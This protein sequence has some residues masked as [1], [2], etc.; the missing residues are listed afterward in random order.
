MPTPH[1]DATDD[2]IDQVMGQ[3][4][5]EVESRTV[6]VSALSRDDGAAWFWVMPRRIP[7]GDVYQTWVLER[8]PS[9]EWTVGSFRSRRTGKGD[10]TVP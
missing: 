9:G 8:A 5:Q 4:P 2:E 1:R 6:T 3:L 7:L 10:I